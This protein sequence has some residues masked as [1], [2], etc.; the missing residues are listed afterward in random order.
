MSRSAKIEIPEA[1]K[2]F[3]AY[4][5][6]GETYPTLALRYNVSVW[7]ITEIC[8]VQGR[9]SELRKDNSIFP[10]WYKQHKNLNLR[11]QPETYE[12]FEEL[13]NELYGGKK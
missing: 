11:Y 3:T 12:Q 1:K 4:W 7:L 9:F 10:I 6:G 5:K 13:C 2:I 8:K